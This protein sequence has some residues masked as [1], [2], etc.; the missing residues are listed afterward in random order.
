MTIPL[1]RQSTTVEIL[2][3][4]QTFGWQSTHFKSTTVEILFEIQTIHLSN[5]RWQSTTVEILFEIQTFLYIPVY[6]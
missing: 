4:I 1:A 5:S 6:Q 3:E 2:F